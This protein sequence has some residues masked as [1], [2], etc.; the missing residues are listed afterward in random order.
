MCKGATNMEN[1]YL[2]KLTDEQIKKIPNNPDWI[3]YHGGIPV[4]QC[5]GKEMEY[6]INNNV[7]TAG[8]CCGHGKD[9]PTA[10]IDEN[11]VNIVKKLN[12]KA[13]KYYLTNEEYS[14]L[15]EI[16]LKTGDLFR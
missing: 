10:L 13:E 8:C 12:Y 3:K 9:I 7:I 5:I 14:N 2:I 11:S 4:D 16:E 6:L 1:V 15:Y